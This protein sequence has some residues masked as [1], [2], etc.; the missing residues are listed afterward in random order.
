[1]EID[2]EWNTSDPIVEV[3]GAF[4]RRVGESI[5]HWMAFLFE[6]LTKGNEFS[7]KMAGEVLDGMIRRLEFALIALKLR[8]VDLTPTKERKRKLEADDDYTLDPAEGFRVVDRANKSA[9]LLDQESPGAVACRES[10]KSAGQR[11]KD[12]PLSCCKSF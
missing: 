1:M 8:S 2:K 11:S 10:L 5:K 7:F 3:V 6:G 9:R 12:K 4:D